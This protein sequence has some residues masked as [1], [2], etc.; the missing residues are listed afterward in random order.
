MYDR[1]KLINRIFYF[2]RIF[3]LRDCRLSS[4]PPAP[5]SPAMS[6]QNVSRSALFCVGSRGQ[7]STTKPHRLMDC[8]SITANVVKSLATFTKTGR[9]HRVSYD[10][11]CQW[12]VDSWAKGSV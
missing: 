12:I 4:H 1:Q 8:W 7:G 11:I 6:F 5:V 2:I 10:T 9:Q 3:S